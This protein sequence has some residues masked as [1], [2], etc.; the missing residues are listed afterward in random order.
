[1]DPFPASTRFFLKGSSRSP[2]KENGHAAAAADPLSAFLCKARPDQRGAREK[3]PGARRRRAPPSLRPHQNAFWLHQNH[4]YPWD[5]S[6]GVLRDICT[7]PPGPIQRPKP[8]L[9]L[10]LAGAFRK[11]PQGAGLTRFLYWS[12]R[13]LRGFPGCP[14]LGWARKACRSLRAAIGPSITLALVRSDSG[15]P[16]G[17]T[18]RPKPV[19][20][21][22]CECYEATAGSE[23]RKENWPACDPRA[24]LPGGH[25]LRSGKN[26]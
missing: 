2:R 16:D 7:G 5:P 4:L 18:Q 10:A 1:L 24:A 21:V 19:R 25:G 8:V 22:E 23:T 13:A 3:R 6:G 9:S 11:G 12:S 20:Y 15:P 26:A 14:G 17:P